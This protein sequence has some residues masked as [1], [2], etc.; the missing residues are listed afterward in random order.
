MKASTA[1]VFFAMS[2]AAALAAHGTTGYADGRTPCDGFVLTR[3][4]TSAAPYATSVVFAPEDGALVVHCRAEAPGVGE[5]A[6]KTA[7]KG[8]WA[9]A[10]SFEFFIDTSGSGKASLLHLALSPN[11]GWWDERAPSAKGEDL[12]WSVSVRTSADSYEATARL[13]WKSLGLVKRP[14]TGAKWRINIGRN[15]AGESG[16]TV[17][18]SFAATGVRYKEP[19]KFADLYFGSPEEVEAV[20]RESIGKD[21]AA[22]RAE[23]S[24]A[25]MEGEFVEKLAA[26]GK[27]G[28]AEL[29][30]EIRDELSVARKL[31]NFKR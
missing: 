5:R 31:A 8:A 11:G 30:V 9:C 12:D 3:D 29:L 22:I 18:S 13:P 23:L 19:A 21:L 28:K 4:N 25:G 7:G 15:F 1:F 10:E 26:F 16:E 17:F 2:A 14:A 20:K 6:A 24:A 27:T